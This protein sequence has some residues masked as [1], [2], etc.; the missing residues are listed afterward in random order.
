MPVVTIS[1]YPW[2][3]DILALIVTFAGALLWLRMLDT[4]A[5]TA[6]HLPA[7]VAQADPHRHRPDLRAVLAAV[8]R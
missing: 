5:R 8:Q 4:L 2:L 3:Q 1:P 6:H 7:P